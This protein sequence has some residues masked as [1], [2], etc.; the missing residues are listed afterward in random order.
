MSLNVGES[1]AKHPLIAVT[2]SLLASNLKFSDGLADDINP[3]RMRNTVVAVLGPVGY[4]E[5]KAQLEAVASEHVAV[6]AHA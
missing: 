3:S 1:L 2:T 6:T 4:H 5:G